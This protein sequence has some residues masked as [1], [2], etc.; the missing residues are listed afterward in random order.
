M[1]RLVPAVL[2][3]V[4]SIDGQFVRSFTVVNIHY[5]SLSQSYISRLAAQYV[6]CVS[7]CLIHL[8]LRG[9]VRCV[10]VCLIHLPLRRT[11][12]CVSVCLIHLPLRR[13]Q[14]QRSPDRR[15]P[16]SQQGIAEQMIKKPDLMF[17]LQS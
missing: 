12:R 17:S 7:V 1:F 8:P 16:V 2:T 5:G 14:S 15:R 9:N 11:V 6:K 10:S 4:H 13:V 3:N